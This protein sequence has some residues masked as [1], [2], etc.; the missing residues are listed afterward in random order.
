MRPAHVVCVLVLG[1][2]ALAGCSQYSAWDRSHERTYGVTYDADSRTG[3]LQMTIRPATSLAP[4]PA[5]GVNDATLSEIARI[6]YDASRR[7]VPGTPD[8]AGN[9]GPDK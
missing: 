6:L 4:S 7:S 1:L 9:G 8:L 5:A 3:A 2:Y